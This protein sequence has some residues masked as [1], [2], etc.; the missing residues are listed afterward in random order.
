MLKKLLAIALIGSA[1]GIA[2]WV[3]L[4]TKPK[5]T[6]VIARE[7]RVPDTSF[8]EPPSLISDVS[9][10]AQQAEL[11]SKDLDSKTADSP[12]RAATGNTHNCDQE[13]ID[14]VNNLLAGIELDIP[15]DETNTEAGSAPLK[16]PYEYLS[17]LDEHTLD[18]LARQGFRD[19]M[20]V[21]GEQ[22]INSEEQEDKEYARQLLYKAGVSGS[23]YSLTG[24]ALSYYDEYLKTVDGG[25]LEQAQE[26]YKNF[27]NTQYLINQ[28]APIAETE[29]QGFRGALINEDLVSN[30]EIAKSQAESLTQFNSDRF[31][32]GLPA[33]GDELTDSQLAEARIVSKT[34]KE[35][36]STER[37]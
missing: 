27:Q 12:Q 16:A 17:H 20:A 19:A 28:L 11:P 22:L 2:I 23:V 6:E 26:A 21:R 7:T 37:N 35:C 34:L 24:L 1:L 31:K 30:E 18:Q 10:Q 15:F 4:A 32:Q 29:D 5:T 36:L 25:S 3:D 33:V 14:K 9:K 8:S 13:V